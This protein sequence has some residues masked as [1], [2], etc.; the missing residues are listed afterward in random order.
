MRLVISVVAGLLLATPSAAF[1]PFLG[2][3]VGAAEIEHAKT[4][5]FEDRDVSTIIEPYGEGG[6]SVTWASVIRIDGRRDMPGVRLV[7]RRM[8]FEPV[9][10]GA[11]YLHVPD[12]DPFKVR[13]ALEP[14]EGDA[15]AW[16]SVQGD[17]LDIWVTALNN[18]GE[19][20][21]QLHRRVR[22]EV[23]LTL[24][25]EA[26]VGGVVRARGVGRMVRVD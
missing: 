23:G 11:Y 3:Y 15:L 2:K 22:N 10:G 1:E 7:E 8:A 16:A 9:E 25:F 4:G 5:E 21:L 18:A 12:Y 14:M 20:E 26:F 19:A 6:F 24:D 17:T 13:E